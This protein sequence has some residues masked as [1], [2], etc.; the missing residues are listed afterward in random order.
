MALHKSNDVGHGGYP[1]VALCSQCPQ[2]PGGVIAAV[3][4]Q[5]NYLFFATLFFVH[6]NRIQTHENKTNT[7]QKMLNANG[8][9]AC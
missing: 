3:M 5:S 2:C 6:A 1:G 9:G 8:V 7:T 4:S